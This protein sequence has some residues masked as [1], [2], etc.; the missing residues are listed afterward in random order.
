MAE[1]TL[2]K[3][4][5][6]S[7]ADDSAAQE[8]DAASTEE[9]AGKRILAQLVSEE[10]EPCGAP[11]DLPAEITSK[12]LQLLTNSLLDDEDD[13]VPFSFYVNEAEITKTLVEVVEEQNLTSEEVVTIVYQPQ[14]VFK[15][16]AIS[17]CTGT[18]P[19]H[20]DNIVDVAFSPNGRQLA[21]GSGDKTVRFWDIH[22][23]TPERTC[24]GHKHWVQ[25]VAWS[26]DGNYVASGASDNQVR[27]WRADTGQPACKPLLGHKKYITWIA[28]EPLHC[29]PDK[30]STRFVSASKDGTA[31]VWDLI[32]GRMMMSFTSHTKGI[33][34][35]KWG[36]AGF[37]YT[38]SQDTTIKVWRV[39]D[40][41]LCRTLN[42][43]A[44]WV[45]SL[46]LSTDSA[47]RSGP[48]NEH[49]VIV[50]DMVQ[51]SQ[52]KY[53]KVRGKEE[54]LVSASEDNTLYLWT[55][56]TSKKPVTRMTGHQRQVNFVQFSP[57]GRL[58]ASCSF[59]KSAKL[60]NGVTGTFMGTFRGHVGPVFRCT[61]AGDSRLLI[62]ASED[63]TIKLWNVKTQALLKDLP[64]HAGSVFAVDWAPNGTLVASGGADK[65]LKL[66]RS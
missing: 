54:R 42:G 47:I 4:A 28:W 55:P 37:I 65:T 50:G 20:T 7:L 40:G 17:Q 58:I 46:S 38:A 6:V 24:K 34:C 63:S 1:E 29:S 9:T 21:T 59:D 44:H 23:M 35:V 49:G 39:S 48:F 27:V 5:N 26:P 60:W 66:W 61:W 56:E 8:E 3:R 13:D 64:G 52:A 43:H 11:L 12:Q 30:V 10:G 36:G 25:C 41:A 33:S 15:V 31:R 45:N 51:T 32:Q 53:A 22:T 18:I 2:A 14:A 19:G 16:R 57:D 62:T